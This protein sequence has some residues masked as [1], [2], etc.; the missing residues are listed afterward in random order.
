MNKL[1]VETI[2]PRVTNKTILCWTNMS[3]TVNLVQLDDCDHCVPVQFWE[4]FSR[5]P[6]FSC[7]MWR[8]YKVIFVITL[9]EKDE[10]KI[11]INNK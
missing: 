7:Q 6:L 4:S 8:C 2:I 9:F 10:S 3:D 5:L 11:E 1:H